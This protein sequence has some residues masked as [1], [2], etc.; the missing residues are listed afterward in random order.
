[1]EYL[2]LFLASVS[3]VVLVF[4][5]LNAFADK[6]KLKTVNV[7]YVFL[8]IC[9]GL[10]ILYFALN[11]IFA[12]LMLWYYFFAVILISAGIIALLKTNL[13]TYNKIIIIVLIVVTLYLYYDYRS[14]LEIKF[15]VILDNKRIFNSNEKY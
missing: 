1:M 13:K 6:I 7:I 2:Y 11:I 3:L 5:L 4:F 10:P 9:F 8:S 14:I 12:F 15:D